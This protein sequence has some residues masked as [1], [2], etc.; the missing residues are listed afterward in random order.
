MTARILEGNKIR[1]QIFAELG[2]EIAELTARGI[3][4]GLAAVL[5]GAL[6]AVP[7]VLAPLLAYAWPTGPPLCRF[8]RFVRLP[9]VEVTFLQSRLLYDIY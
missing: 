9:F 7:C 2:R 8:V 3:R 5:V 1:G 4:P 6:G